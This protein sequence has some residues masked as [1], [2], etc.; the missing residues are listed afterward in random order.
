[1][2]DEKNKS[3]SEINFWINKIVILAREKSKSIPNDNQ[4]IREGNE[5]IERQYVNLIDVFKWIWFSSLIDQLW[6][7]VHSKQIKNLSIFP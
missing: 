7:F 2:K 3:S 6:S 5:K 4:I 1:M